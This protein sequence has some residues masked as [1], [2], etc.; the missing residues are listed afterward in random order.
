MDPTIVKFFEDRGYS[1]AVARGI[2]AGV[3]AEAASNPSAKNK[4]SGAYGLGQWL[5]SR[6]KE[7]IRRYGA[8]PTKRQQLE[9]LDWELKGGDHGGA[10]VTKQST[11][12]GALN[13]YI[14]RFMR[15]A[16]GA[17]TSGDIRRGR[18]A[19]GLASSDGEST[20]DRVRAK[21]AERES[22]GPSISKVYEAYKAGRMSARDAAQFENDVLEGRVMLPRG[23]ALKRKPAAP[24]L[25]AGVIRAFNSHEMDEEDRVQVEKDLRDGVFSLPR[26]AKLQRPPERT[27]GEYLAMGVRPILQGVGTVADLA[28]A[29]IAALANA[30]P[31]EQGLSTSPF[32]DAA[33]E[34]SDML[35]IS[36]PESATERLL[37]SGIEN[38]TAGLITAGGGVAASGARGIT[39][40]VAKA[41]GAAPVLDAVAGA[42]SGV[43]AEAARQAGAGPV[44]QVVAGLAGGVGAVGA[45]AGARG[46]R[47]AMK[48]TTA[49]EVVASVPRETVFDRAG[50][51]TDEG[52]EIVVQSKVAP[53]ELRAAYDEA[54]PTVREGVA[55]DEGAVATARAANDDVRAPA[56]DV[57]PTRIEEAPPM[58]KVEEPAPQSAPRPAPEAPPAAALPEG[59]AARVAEA[60]SE[61]IPLTRGQATQDFEIQDAEQTLRAAASKEGAEARAF[62]IEQ[63]DKIKEATAR[64]QS[65]F[66]DTTLS[67]TDRGQAVKDAIRE[68]KEE[69]RQGVSALY[70]AAADTPGHDVPIPKD[71]IL[72][73]ADRLILDTPMDQGSKDALER[74]LAKYGLLG[75]KAKKSGRFRTVLTD[76]GRKIAI[77]GEVEP[78]TLKNAE[79]FR[80]ALNQAWDQKGLMG[81]AIRAL[82]QAVDDVLAKTVSSERNDLFKQ[83]RQAARQQKETFQAKDI[84]QNLADWKKGTR[85]DVVLPERAISQIFAGGKEGLT[86]LKK[87]KALLLS[88]PTEKSRAAWKAI[89]A[90]GVGDLFK[91]AYTTNANL[92]GGSIGSVSGAKLN[93]AIEKFGADKLKALLDEAEFNQ[94]MKLRRVIGNATIP[95][96]NTTNPSGSAFKL[97]RFLGPFANR[98]SPLAP[99]G[100]AMREIVNK[101]REIV[102]TQ[103]TLRGIKEFTAEEAALAPFDSDASSAADLLANEF[104]QKFIEVAG[105]GRLVP[106]IIASDGSDDND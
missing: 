14:K 48:A 57:A 39:G 5:G 104:I 23:S 29:P 2:A 31:G 54:P 84:V 22:S 101:G 35:G 55:N 82:D 21:R 73:E 37:G 105:S 95:I 32:R 8:N 15:P 30:L 24:V 71:A 67:A 86:N 72:D 42:T 45:V 94:L 59:A 87:I 65:A 103:K 41:L 27:A 47:Q 93:S 1:K 34:A 99:Y 79:A 52:R 53:D 92:G 13:A 91:Q 40:E 12:T 90:Q 33:T 81:G 50:N 17:E 10:A 76:D 64:F 51:L 6:K 49:D 102:E 75:S 4:S 16:K 19:L 11:E 56:N 66:G 100:L 60:Q 97:M 70:K 83:A 58:R 18:A 7:L 36:R 77:R 106:S 68:L 80:Q 28:A 85:T 44:G 78:L 46:V 96:K 98:L 25:P 62:D 63:A 3:H 26:G 88:K 74:A 43:S 20:F 69:G 9:F 89:Q 38:A 61:G